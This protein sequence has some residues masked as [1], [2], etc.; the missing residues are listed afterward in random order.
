MVACQ[1]AQA[2]LHLLAR[3]V[4]HCTCY[5]LESRFSSS[6]TSMQFCSRVNQLS[7]A[8]TESHVQILIW[9]NIAPKS[10]LLLSRWPGLLK[11]SSGF[12]ILIVQAHTMVP[13]NFWDES[14]L[15][16]TATHTRHTLKY[17][18][19]NWQGPD[20]SCLLLVVSINWADYRLKR[21]EAA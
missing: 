3:M 14:F 10:A 12:E 1:V 13:I 21:Q 16:T 19:I 18:S 15:E 6:S 2:L 8:S 17:S 7:L 5:V 9:N 11:L 20:F 4:S